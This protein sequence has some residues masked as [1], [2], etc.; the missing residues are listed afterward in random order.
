MAGMTDQQGAIEVDA[1]GT[2]TDASPREVSSREA[3]SGSARRAALVGVIGAGAALG[4]GEFVSALIGAQP[5]PVVAVGGRFI[6]RFAGA[7]KDIAVSIFGTNDKPALIAGTVVIACALGAATAV[8]ARRRAWLPLAVFCAFGAFGAWAQAADP[9]VDAAPAVIVAALSVPAGV[10]ATRRLLRLAAPHTPTGEPSDAVR[11]ADPIPR[12]DALGRRRFIVTAGALGAGSAG[13]AVAARALA[14]GDVVEAARAAGLPVPARRAAL[15][16][17]AAF[18]AAG[19]SRY[20]T[21]VKDFYR[22]DTALL[23]PQV[24]ADSWDLSI[25]GLVARPFSIGY[26]ELLSLPSI[27]QVVTLQCVSNEVG[28]EL[29]G[30]AVWQGVA[31]ATLLDRAGVKDSAE[32]V[33]STSVDGWNCGFP[34]SVLDGERPAMIAYAMNGERLPARHGFPARL[35]VSGLYGYVSATKWLSTIELTTWDGTDGY[36]VPRGWSKKGPIKL[37]SRIDVP[38]SGASVT[39][40]RT[41]IAGVAWRPATGISAVQISIDGGDWLDCELG[42]VASEHTWVQWKRDWDATPGDHEVV[43]R[44]VDARGEPQITRYQEPAPDG[45]TGLHRVSFTVAS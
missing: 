2:A 39:P 31:L 37:T 40:G 28:D 18:E 38:R 12:P 25:G 7:L 44:A 20:V 21:P 6:D 13:L 11:W 36:W 23:V 26:D 19:A 22:I 16:D 34:I 42:E 30:T 10:A 4:V 5:S 14:R 17:T 45:A 43:V 35:V 9:Q 15:P 1:P 8:G 24:D 41:P 33:F 3:S 32:Q 27:E 29:V